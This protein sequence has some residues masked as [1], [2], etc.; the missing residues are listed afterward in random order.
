[1]KIHPMW[2]EYPQIEKELQ[3]CLNLIGDSIKI[4]NK[5]IEGKVTQLMSSGGKMLRPAYSLMFSQYK[6]E[7]NSEKA[8]AIA[9]A[10][11]VLHLATLVHDDV[12]DESHLRRGQETLNVQYNNRVAVYTGDYLF[13]VC[14]QI[15]KQ[16]AQDASFFQ[17]DRNV[18]ENILVGEL[19]QM[20]MAYNPNMTMRNYLTQISGKTAQLFALSCY[21][22]AYEEDSPKMARVA[23][24]IGNNIGMAFQIIDDVLDYTQDTDTAGKPMMSDLKKGIYTAPLLY[25]MQKNRKAFEP[26]I[27]KKESITDEELNEV[28][29]LVQKHNGEARAKE[30][31]HKYTLKA[32]KQIDQLP[33]NPIKSALKNI[34]EQVLNREI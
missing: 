15:L 4:K 23:Y 17:L 1:M 16:Y 19:N 34:T 26:Y 7:Q 22:G 33:E 14:F 11:E 25:A 2:K 5:E 18:M 28:Y 27:L 30:L 13:T 20:D 6:Q 21:A 9:A 3:A 24:N 10:V 32:L 29:S 31:A 12:I 8:H